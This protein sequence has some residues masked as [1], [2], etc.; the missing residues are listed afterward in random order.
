MSMPIR[1]REA[2]EEIY[3]S[4][5]RV[6]G[7]MHGRMRSGVSDSGLT[8]PQMILLRILVAKGKATSTD[9]SDILGVTPANITGLVAKLERGGFVSR[10][11]D[12][13]DRRVVHL[14][15]TDKAHRAV[16]KAQDA[17]IKNLESAFE[18]WSMEDVRQLQKLLARLEKAH[19]PATKP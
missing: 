14:A 4:F 16:G 11:R 7:L 17:A 19:R 18:E 1:K 6:M 3:A 9:L 2:V 12:R 8:L 13:Q 5:R 15:P 10:A